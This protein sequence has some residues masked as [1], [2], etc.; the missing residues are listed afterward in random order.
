MTQTIRRSLT[1][2]H[3]KD[4]HPNLKMGKELRHFSEDTQ[5]ASEYQEKMLNIISH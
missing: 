5:V 3:S 1:T 4:E 2:P